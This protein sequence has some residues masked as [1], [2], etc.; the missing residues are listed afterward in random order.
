MEALIDAL[1]K[2]KKVTGDSIHFILPKEV[3]EV[4]DVLVPLNIVEEL[5]ND[6]C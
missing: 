1:R 6:L 4:E 2:D 5:A 3:G